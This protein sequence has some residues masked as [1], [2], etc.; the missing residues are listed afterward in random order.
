MAKNERS[1]MEEKLQAALVDD[2][3]FLKEIVRNACQKIMEEEMTT[4]LG[5][6]AHERTEERV[7]YR[8]GYKPRTLRTRVGELNLLVPKDRE[9]RFSTQLFSRY[10]RSEKALVL[11]LQ[12]MYLKGVS[13]RKVAQ[14]TEALCGTSFSKSQVSA[15]SQELDQEIKR[16]RHRPLTGTHIYLI[17]DCLY[18]KARIGNEV[19]SQGILIVKGINEEGRREILSVD[20]ANTESETTWSETFKSLKERG[21]SGVKLIVSDDHIGLVKAAKRYFQGAVWQRCQFHF[22]RNIL[23]AIPKKDRKS[24]AIEIKTVFDAPDKNRA[25]KRL[26]EVIDRLKTRYSKAAERLSEGAVDSIACLSFPTSHRRRIRTTN[27]LERFNEEIRRR[28]RVVRIFPNPESAIRLITALAIEQTEEW[29]TGKRYLNME[30]LND[31]ES[32]TD[33]QHRENLISIGIS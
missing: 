29:L 26:D 13:T 28:T 11:A 27:S 22:M 16:F 1:G 19:V 33:V 32:S 7:G 12:E 9:G 3:D 31:E 4:F 30:D 10:Q 8:N 21:L 17:V 5:A 14:I 24:V 2:E 23:D 20:I 25:K 15:L 18:E 6:E